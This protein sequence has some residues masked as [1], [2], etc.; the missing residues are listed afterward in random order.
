MAPR[1]SV[2]GPCLLGGVRRQRP[3]ALLPACSE[4]APVTSYG[5]VPVASPFRGFCAHGVRACSRTCLLCRRLRPSAPSQCGT[6]TRRAIREQE[7]GFFP[8]PSSP[9]GPPSCSEKGALKIKSPHPRTCLTD[10]RERGREKHRPIAS[11]TSGAWDDAPT[12]RAARLGLRR[13]P[14]GSYCHL[15]LRHHTA[16]RLGLLSGQCRGTKE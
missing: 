1:G 15:H 3:L 7:T 4:A 13:V 5:S 6:P 14:Y 10:L 12:N 16:S 11:Y 9:Q 2:P 8:H